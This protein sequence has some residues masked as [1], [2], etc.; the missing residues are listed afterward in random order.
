MPNYED[1]KSAEMTHYKRLCTITARDFVLRN[2]MIAN[3]FEAFFCLFSSS[4]VSFQK[5]PASA[6]EVIKYKENSSEWNMRKDDQINQALQMYVLL[7]RNKQLFAGRV[8]Q[9]HFEIVRAPLLTRGP[10]LFLLLLLFACACFCA[11]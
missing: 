6:H 8:A 11:M 2:E 1:V 10:P 3:G 7:L 4:V 9:T 5:V